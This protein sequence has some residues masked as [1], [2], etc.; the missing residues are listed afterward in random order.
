MKDAIRIDT[1]TWLQSYIWDRG[2]EQNSNLGATSFLEL[3]FDVFKP[4]N[5]ETGTVYIILL[6]LEHNIGNLKLKKTT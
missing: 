6:Y 2:I 5:R 4:S 3:K 1:N